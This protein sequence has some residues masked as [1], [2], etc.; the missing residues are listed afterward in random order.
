MHQPIIKYVIWDWNGTLIDDAWLFVELMN[1]EL[2]VRNLP[3][4]TVDDY[5]HCFT[6]PVKKYYEV[7]GF[8]FQQEDFKEVGYQFIQKFKKR[9]F[10][11]NLFEH[12][13]DIL[14]F[15]KKLNIKQSIVSAQENNLLN[16]TVKHYQIQHY[17]DTISGI[18]H[19]Y[20]DD[21]IKLAQSV[22]KKIP[23]DNREIV[24]IGDSVH[25]FEVAEAL[26][27]KCILFSKGHYSKKRLLRCDC[28]IIDNH[29]ELEK[30]YFSR[31]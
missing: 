15:T 1:E 19:Y 12:S 9:K 31:I 6:F 30:I 18:S 21:K 25:D 11:A 14:A 20:A 22:R 28:P 8:D 27:V 23:Y 7:L 2:N 3:Q 4:I 16:Q 26:G 13:A 24:L 29:R 10:E 5:R 17:F